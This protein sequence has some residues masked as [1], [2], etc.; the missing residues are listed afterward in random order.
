MA[1]MISSGG[2]LAETATNVK[3][4]GDMAVREAE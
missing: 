3:I 2:C 4:A 1:A